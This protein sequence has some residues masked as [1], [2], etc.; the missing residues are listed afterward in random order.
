MRLD[1]RGVLDSLPPLASKGAAQRAL[2]AV[3]RKV[4]PAGFSP[5][6]LGKQNQLRFP[7]PL[8]RAQITP[9]INFW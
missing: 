6:A 5:L 4:G 1:K 3:S 9:K 7:V 8:L 2:L